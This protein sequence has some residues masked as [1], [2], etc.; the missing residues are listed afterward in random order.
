MS[1]GLNVPGKR[2]VGLLKIIFTAPR[3]NERERRAAI[4]LRRIEMLR[5]RVLVVV[6]CYTRHC[7][8][9]LDVGP[10]QTSKT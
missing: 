9:V 3:Q 10:E 1:V 8:R 6:L 7:G 5:C 2:D 4:L